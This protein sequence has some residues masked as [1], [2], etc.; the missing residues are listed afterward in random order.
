M[1]E[2][3]QAEEERETEREQLMSSTAS[4]KAKSR[5]EKIFGAE[6][7]Q[8]SARLQALSERFAASLARLQTVAAKTGL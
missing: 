5:L 3:L 7:A 2:E 8:A 1:L 6:R 4:L